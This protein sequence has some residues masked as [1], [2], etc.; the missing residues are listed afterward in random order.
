[1]E[2]LNLPYLK[3]MAHSPVRNYVIPGLTSWLIGGRGPQG[4]VVRLFECERNH[5]EGIVPHSHRFDLHSIVVDGE[6]TNRLWVTRAISP[7]SRVE[8]GE[9][10]YQIL[11]QT[12][13]DDGSM[14]NYS[15]EKG[16]IVAAKA[17]N[18][19]YAAGD[20]YFM[21][22]DEIHDISFSKGAAV[23]VFEGPQVT[24]ES[25]VLQPRVDNTM[26]PTLK[27]EPWMFKR[28]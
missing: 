14:G 21:K 11:K 7:G 12:L 17:Y 13:V 6:V 19:T 2:Q 18:S 27:V 25:L 4:Q 23:L 15:L 20:S 8:Y 16:A 1:M 10:C 22:S 3:K 28:D 24:R 26:V 5:I 9:D